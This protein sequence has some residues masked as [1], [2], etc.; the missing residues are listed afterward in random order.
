VNIRTK[1]IALILLSSLI[2]ICIVAFI[3]FTSSLSTLKTEVGKSLQVGAEEAI[4]AVE[5]YFDN[6]V[7]NFKFWTM[8]PV[9][10]DILSDDEDG[11]IKN[12][13]MTL[14]KQYS[15]FLEFIVVNTEQKILANTEKDTKINLKNLLSSYDK[16]KL[17]IKPQ[18]ING[19]NT[20]IL[21]APIKADYDSNTVIGTL[22]GV[23]NW[24]HIKSTLSD[25]SISGAEQDKNHFLTLNSNKDGINLYKTANLEEQV[26]SEIT[27]LAYTQEVGLSEVNIG[28]EGFLIGTALS[29]GYGSFPN[30]NWVIQL[31]ISQ[32]IAYAGA[33]DL[34]NKMLITFAITLIL[35]SVFGWIG[36]SKIVNPIVSITNTMKLLS[37]GDTSVEVKWLTNKDEIGDMAKALQVFK[38]S[39]IEK[40]R[41]EKEQKLTEE[42]TKEEKKQAMHDLAN[43]FE[44]Q[45]QKTINIIILEVQNLGK[46]T[47]FMQKNVTGVDDKAKD[48]TVASQKTAQNVN[49]VVT[50]LSEMT[51]AVKEISSQV[52]KSTEVINEAVGKAEHAGSSAESLEN[53]TTEI[54]DVVQLIQDIA[55]KINLLALNATIE[56]AR[57]G[58][59]GKG[60]AVVA[61]EIKNLASQT[62]AATESI[63]KQIQAVQVV[64]AEVSEALNAITTSIH[65]VNE[66]SGGIS[67][68]VEEQSAT[69]SE[70]ANNMQVAAQ[71]TQE[72]D[73]SISKINESVSY[74][75][76][77][78]VQMFEASQTLSKEAEQLNSSVSSFLK[79]IR[80]G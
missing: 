14:K 6:A 66:Y 9:M 79:D 57:A 60:F 76:E 27:P 10:Q 37:G 65:E 4:S 30:P 23:I 64:S 72:V 69:T 63:S 2:P 75:N 28:G 56:S 45:I 5:Q 46:T 42:R 61:S 7:V 11:E 17:S 80:E 36:V 25:V 35:V 39:S 40:N 32:D 29:K 19:I 50:A 49:A 20:Y 78:S 70:I 44:K 16:T 55:E 74:A 41:L 47:E 34:A 12:Q 52:I 58:E 67:S 1:N 59:A 38:E 73:N 33:H 8:M 22:V 53:V 15:L 3:S 21:L 68:A 54:G 26:D 48:A 43:K 18:K 31:F 24:H 71:G 51:S 77:S 62:T 13:L